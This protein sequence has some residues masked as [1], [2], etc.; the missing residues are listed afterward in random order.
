MLEIFFYSFLSSLHIYLC[1]YLFYYFSISKEISIKHNIFELAFYGAFLLCLIALFLNFFISLNKMVNTFIFLIPFIIFF[2]FLFNKN[3]LIKIL[4]YSIPISILCVLTISFDGTYRP[5]AGSYHLPYISILNENKLLIGINN[6][7]YRF[8][9]TSIFQYLSSIYNNYI[10][11]EKGISI[12]L[13]LFFCNFIAYC[14]YEL[15]I[16]ENNRHVKILIFIIFIFTIFRVNRYSDFGNDAPANLL[17]FYLIIE[18]LKDN[19][20]F[21]KIQK[22]IFASIFIFLN[23]ITLLLALFIPIY[24]IVRKF[25]FKNIFNKISFIS[26]FFLSIY[27]GKNILISGCAMFPVEQ[28]CIENLYWYDKDSNRASNAINA[29][30]ENEAWTKGWVNQIGKKENYRNYNSNFV[31]IKTWTISEGK[32]ITKKLTPFLIFLLLLFIVLKIYDY[33]TNLPSVIKIKI[34]NHYYFCLFLCICG[35][36]LWFLKFPV[37]RYGYSYLISSIAIIFTMYLKNSKLIANQL[38]FNNSINYI[39]IILIFGITVKNSN[40]IYNG[41]IDEIDPW[42]NIYNDGKINSKKKNINIKKGKTTLF[43]KSKIGECYY[44]KSPCTHYFNGNDFNLD[45]IN[46]DNFYG[47]KIYYFKKN[48]L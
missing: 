28:T 7:H 36:L 21:L 20:N 35:S 37:F 19:K 47:Y 29:R 15:K 13:C 44:S 5:D 34:E 38:I 31:W 11:N 16:S 1:G 24:L 23:K 9:H 3:F 14:L 18:T 40:R 46:L 39:I 32:T 26:L 4:T 45:E 33:R 8:G 43:Y 25:E 48:E 2:T 10:F 27:L 17:F 42:P 30:L 22:T 12:P 41:F 6:I